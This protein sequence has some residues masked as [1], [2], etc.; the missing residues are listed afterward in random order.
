MRSPPG[1]VQFW[2]DA[3][4]E[5][6]LVEPNLQH[7]DPEA[8]LLDLPTKA[9]MLLDLSFAIMISTQSNSMQGKKWIGQCSLTAR[10]TGRA[11]SLT[12]CRIFDLRSSSMARTVFPSL[13]GHMLDH[14]LEIWRNRG[15]VLHNHS[16]CQGQPG[17]GYKLL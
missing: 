17:Q 9:P 13:E 5:A 6:R 10:T 15:L 4:P 14:A 12:I 2:T 3:Q 8:S 16:P 7:I 11:F 1:V